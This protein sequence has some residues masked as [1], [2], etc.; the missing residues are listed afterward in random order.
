MVMYLHLHLM[1][2]CFEIKPKNQIK[3][4]GEQMNWILGA[5][6]ISLFDCKFKN[7]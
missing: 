2:D 6:Y 5:F 3:R 4:R 7:I 1:F